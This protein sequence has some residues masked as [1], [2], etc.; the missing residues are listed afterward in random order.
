MVWTRACSDMTQRTSRLPQHSEGVEVVPLC[1]GAAY[2]DGKAEQAFWDRCTRAS[3]LT[4]AESN[5]VGGKE[6]I[7]AYADTC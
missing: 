4:A 5:V 3:D 2:A 1:R 7:K 6:M